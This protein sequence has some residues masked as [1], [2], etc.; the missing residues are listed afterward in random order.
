MRR[1]LSLLAFCLISAPPAR[2]ADLPRYQ[3]NIETVAGSSLNGDGGPATAAQFG[4]I[5]GIA[6]DAAGNLYLSDTDRNC[7]RK[8]DTKGIV[9]TVAGTGT[10]GFAGDGGAATEALL[11]LPYGLAADS[12]GALYVADLGNNRVRRI[13]PDGVISTVAGTGTAGSSGDGGPATAAQLMGPRNLAV[14]A[15]GNLYISEFEGHRVRKVFSTGQIATLAGTGVA[16]L[17][18]DGGAAVA[19]QLAFPAGLALDASGSLYIADSQNQRIRKVL[20]NGVISTALGGSTAITLYTPLSVAID[21]SGDILVGDASFT[22]NAYTPAGK[23]NRVAGIGAPGYAGD[24][25]LAASA[26]LSAVRDLAAAANGNLYIADGVHVRLVDNSGAIATVAGDGY[27]HAVGDGGSALAALLSQPS[28]LALDFGGNLYIADP[29]TQRVRKVGANNVIQT[30]AGTGIAGMGGELMAASASALNSPM[31][32]AVAPTGVVYIADTYNHRIRAVSADGTIATVAGTGTSGTGAENQPWTQTAL[33]GPRGVCVDRQ[34]TLFIVDTSNHRVLRA[35]PG[36]LM[37]TAAGN[38]SPGAAGDGGSARLAQLDQ[39]GAC[40]VDTAGNLFIADTLNHR[41]RKVTAAGIISTLAG[42]GQPGASGD[43]GPATAACLNSP[44]GVTADDNGNVFVADT[45]NQVIRQVTPDGIIHLIAGQYA[46]GFAGD[47]GPATSALLDAPA[48]LVLDGAGDLYLADSGNNRVR[49]LVPGAPVPVAPVIV[50]QPIS[51]VSAASLLTGP[52]APGAL[53]TILGAG[54]GPDSGVNAS[55]DASGRMPTSLAGVQVLFDGVAVP[56]FYVQAGQLTAQAPYTLAGKSVTNVQVSYQ[57]LVVGAANIAVAA[58]VPAIFPAVVNQ[59]G[60][61]NLASAPA[62]RGTIV[63][64]YATG[65]GL[66]NPI[67]VEGIPASA[68]YPQPVLPV[69]VSVA[70]V[71]AQVLFAA[72]APGLV[73]ILQVNAVVPASLTAVGQ[74][75]LALQ[76]GDAVSAAIPVWLQ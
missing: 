40:A 73:G 74:Q 9:T 70:G 6:L 55:F 38:G 19:A 59:D 28:A 1:Y 32:V 49:R 39:P 45:G 61:I 60:S 26:L 34:D 31:G 17:R 24:G 42:S 36:A 67:S 16:G 7:V 66:T 22:V 27:L 25:G 33:R 54:L 57:D 14:D 63:T 52:V 48:G 44:S 46:A 35:A 56:L 5:Q 10:A 3:Y 50:L 43:E 12:S 37:A 20:P 71:G 15:S 11:N 68:P 76:V 18:G 41:I 29:G 62:A 69:S 30:L 64:F 21:T 4:A 72:S 23:W 13:G 8:V 2:A 65:A 75:T 47:G 58:A 51:V 53:V